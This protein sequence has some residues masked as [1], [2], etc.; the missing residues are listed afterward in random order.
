MRKVLFFAVSLFLFLRLF[1]S[2]VSA[3]GMGYNIVNNFF[4]KD[5][6]FNE[7]AFAEVA[8]NNPGGAITVRITSGDLNGHPD[9]IAN[10][11][12]AV[13][14]Y[15]LNVVW[16]PEDWR[17]TTPADFRDFWLPQL[18]QITTGTI[19]L[20]TEYNYHYGHPDFYAQILSLAL[21]SPIGNRV[22]MTN[23]NITNPSGLQGPFGETMMEY[24]EFLRKVQER[25]GNCL[26][27]VPVWA[28]SIY[29]R[30]SNPGEAVN[31]FVNQM[32][33]FISTLE[34][35]GVNLSGKQL[36]IPE[37]GLDPQIPIGQRLRM[38]ADFARQLED[39]IHNDPHFKALFE[40]N[41]LS[42]SSITFLIMDDK[43]GKQYLLVKDEDGNWVII[44]YGAL[45]LMGGVGPGGVAAC[46]YATSIQK[47]VLR[48]KSPKDVE[49]GIRKLKLKEA[50]VAD[51]QPLSK[52]IQAARDKIRPPSNDD[53][54]EKLPLSP[55][56]GYI[57]YY[58]C[59]GSELKR[60]G[61]DDE[62]IWLGTPDYAP[63]GAEAIYDVGDW[64]TTKET[65]GAESPRIAGK[66][67]GGAG[68]VSYNSPSSRVLGSQTSLSLT[69]G[70]GG[71]VGEA[72]QSEPV[73]SAGSVTV[74]LSLAEMISEWVEEI[75][76][77]VKRLVYKEDIKYKEYLVYKVT[78]A[79]HSN[80]SGTKMVHE[81]TVPFKIPGDDLEEKHG[82]VPGEHDDDEGFIIE[83]GR[84]HIDPKK[85]GMEEAEDHI[86]DMTN[87][88]GW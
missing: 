5:G 7:A 44:E 75:I 40:N 49:K 84:G 60:L 53:K 26:N 82:R 8:R 85:K 68:F 29:G 27:D 12:A 34:S 9:L 47:L 55:C 38:V 24:G 79:P 19:S 37:I 16:Q 22:A 65:R 2:S 15:N 13:R 87:P 57:E 6:R 61:E 70:Q 76:E 32:E 25:C 69:C 56:Q 23:F 88:P 83:G 80:V 73:Y 33:G 21:N 71:D 35:L 18:S 10:I 31:D 39:E 36:V 67:N 45:G 4:D 52:A 72:M 41:G 46:D 64:M 50:E 20:F 54:K 43:T 81:V 30:G 1:P 48:G 86:F 74:N 63:A 78:Y 62:K 14:R 51:W 59:D 28:V 11:Q 42:L 66:N 17:A 77:G 3:Q 58:Y